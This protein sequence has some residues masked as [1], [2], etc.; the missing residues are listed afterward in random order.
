MNK[1][2]L[3]YKSNA[4][5]FFSIKHLSKECRFE[6]F[7]TVALVAATAFAIVAIIPGTRT[8][9]AYGLIG[10]G[11]LTTGGMLALSIVE[12][13]PVDILLSITRLGALVILG[14]AIGTGNTQLAVTGMSIF[15][16]LEATSCAVLITTAAKSLSEGRKVEVHPR[17]VF[18]ALAQMVGSILAAAAIGT[19]SWKVMVAACSINAVALFSMASMEAYDRNPLKAL[20]YAALG[21]I[22]IASAVKIRKVVRTRV[23]DHWREVKNP[24]DTEIELTDRQGNRYRVGPKKTIR[25]PSNIEFKVETYQYQGYDVEYMPVTKWI[26][27]ILDDGSTIQYLGVEYE[28]HWVLNWKTRYDKYLEATRLDTGFSFKIE[29]SSVPYYES[30]Q[31]YVAQH[32]IPAKKL[33]TVPVGGAAGLATHGNT[34]KGWNPHI[35]E[36][37]P[38]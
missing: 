25:V 35:F 8:I 10:V 11:A 2:Q 16:F 18:A 7:Q 32:P 3:P 29:K 31:K 20:C 23:T 26:T 1:I 30:Y 22:S 27:E 24:T 15:A 37:L 12:R 13:K 17:E 36:Y 14:L 21:C 38:T 4:S 6:I 34:S 28:P 5:N 9:G 19:G 33:P